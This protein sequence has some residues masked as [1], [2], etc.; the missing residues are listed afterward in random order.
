MTTDLLTASVNYTLYRRWA[1]VPLH[2][3]RDGQCTC[4]HED[5]A[6]PGKHPMTLHGL[7]DASRD[8]DDA[9]ATWERWPDANV[10]ICT[11]MPSGIVVIDVDGA[12]GEASLAA[13]IARHEP[14]P[15]TLTARTGREGGRHL[16]FGVADQE[17][18]NSA[19][20]LGAKLDVRGQGGYIVAPPSMHISGRRYEW[21]DDA[22]IAPLPDWLRGLMLATPAP[23]S[24]RIATGN[25]SSADLLRRG[26]TYVA[27]ADGAG[28][29][30]R[31][32]ACF[33]LAGHLAALAGEHGETLAEGE[34][35]ELLYD[36]NRRC[37]PP[38]STKELENAVRSGMTNGTP[39]D[40]KTSRHPN[41]RQ[42]ALRGREVHY[43]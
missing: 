10:G 41:H 29:G 1:I 42:I 4:G 2:G 7:R 23:A 25:T 32:G 28:E 12:D 24:R 30:T 27:L 8:P 43:A 14:L 40:P 6:S 5:C 35:I 33:R 20:R 17:I 38:L 15:E 31:N 9:W 39:R 3:I 37:Q 13:I 19:G 11:G 36:F 16:Y 22:P 18:R 26:R 21:I 34:I